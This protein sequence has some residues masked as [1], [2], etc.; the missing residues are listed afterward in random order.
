MKC[1]IGLIF[2]SLAFAVVALSAGLIF[3]KDRV[4]K[5]ADWDDTD[6][7]AVFNFVNSSDEEVIIQRINTS[8]GCT[9]AAPA[10][11][12]YAPGESGSI[13]ANFNVGSRQ[14]MQSNRI[15]VDTNQGSHQLMFRI[16]IPSAWVLSQRVLAWRAVEDNEP[17]EAQLQVLH[18]DV[19]DVV[20]MREAEGWDVSLEKLNNNTWKIVAKPDSMERNQRQ[21]LVLQMIRNDKPDLV[22]NLF[23]RVL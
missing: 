22:A 3:E 6:V 1:R 4:D 12:N 8:C 9:A 13:E 17:K 18:P 2:L 19:T 20:V 21:S 15:T 16:E 10:K 7:K 11:R 14:G 23:L 5:V